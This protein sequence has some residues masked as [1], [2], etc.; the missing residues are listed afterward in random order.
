VNRKSSDMVRLY[1]P[2][3]GA[4]PEVSQGRQSGIA[5]RAAIDFRLHDMA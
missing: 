4:P 5:D 1:G 3:P 2:S